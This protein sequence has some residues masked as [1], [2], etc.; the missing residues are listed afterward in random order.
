MTSFHTISPSPLCTRSLL[1]CLS[2]T[3][4]VCECAR[5]P[6][7]RLT[8]F[9]LLCLF[10]SV[11]ACVYLFSISL[12]LSLVLSLSPS[13]VRA[14]SFLLSLCTHIEEHVYLQRL[15]LL[16]GNFACFRGSTVEH[17]KREEAKP[18]SN[19]FVTNFPESP[20]GIR[21]LMGQKK[22]HI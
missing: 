21:S 5:F 7:A 17:M 19:L 18:L 8:W 13:A 10:L 11:R 9:L 12:L 22:S 4:R 2:L 3:V 16:V 15:A 1:L 14:L 6:A 20:A